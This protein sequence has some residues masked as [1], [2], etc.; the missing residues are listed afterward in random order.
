MRRRFEYIM[1]SDNIIFHAMSIRTDR[2]DDP[3]LL[4]LLNKDGSFVPKDQ[5][6]VN[7]VLNQLKQGKAVNIYT[8]KEVKMTFTLKGI[9]S[10]N[11][12][13]GFIFE[14]NPKPGVDEPLGILF[15]FEIYGQKYAFMLMNS[16]DVM[17]D[18]MQ[19]WIKIFLVYSFTTMNLYHLMRF[20]YLCDMIRRF[21][22]KGRELEDFIVRFYPAGNNGDI[23]YEKAFFK[24]KER[25]S[26]KFERVSSIRRLS[27]FVPEGC[28][29]MDVFLVGGGAGGGNGYASPAGGGSGYTKTYKK[30]NESSGSWNDWVKDGDAIKVK[31]GQEIVI[32]VGKGGAGGIKTGGRTPRYGSDGE[33]TYVHFS[34]EE[35]LYAGGGKAYKGEKHSDG[36]AICAS[37]GT[38]ASE[39]GGWG[40][41]ASASFSDGHYPTS[42]YGTHP[43]DSQGHT[44]RVLEKLISR[45]LPEEPLDAMEIKGRIIPMNQKAI[46]PV[47]DKMEIIGLVQM[48]PILRLKEAEGTE[49]EEEPA[50]Y[51]SCHVR[52]MDPEKVEMVVM[53]L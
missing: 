7:D 47:E 29:E 23:F 39:A 16:F 10:A 6:E 25:I 52:H 51:K 36:Y 4:K 11:N 41:T 38:G 22:H 19:A 35:L 8:G 46:P 1:R 17:K 45:L 43:G 50:A 37:G 18:I 24:Q 27:F 32:Y 5:K 21:K 26:S 2:D 44:T 30:S 49:A 13:T 3:I 12:T 40:T 28:Y 53:A 33:E 9:T 42:K 34:F 14:Y 31:P 48:T 20:I 15:E